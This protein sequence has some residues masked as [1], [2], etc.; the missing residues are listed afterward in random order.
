MSEATPPSKLSARDAELLALY[1]EDLLTDEQAIELNQR[2]H[3]EPTLLSAIAQYAEIEEHLRALLEEEHAADQGD[4]FV[5]MSELRDAEQRAEAVLAEQPMKTKPKK[6]SRRNGEDTPSAKEVAD[7]LWY[8]GKR[9]VVWGPV[10]AVL[11]VALTLVVA[12]RGGESQPERIVEQP[13]ATSEPVPVGP[14]APATPPIVAAL[15]AEYNAQWQ[16]APGGIAP[17][18]GD[19]LAQGLRLVLAGGAVQLTTRS[20]AVVTLQGPT[21]ARVHAEGRVE[22]VHGRLLA[23]CETPE[24]KGFTVFTD[25]AE[26]TDIGT[27]FAVERN[28]QG[29]TITGVLDGHVALGYKV[30]QD[31]P[32]ILRTGDVAGVSAQGVALAPP[33][34]Q[35][36]QIFEDWAN[37]LRP[38]AVSGDA[39]FLERPPPSFPENDEKVHVYREPAGVVLRED[40]TVSRTKPGIYRPTEQR[41]QAV[42]AAGTRVDSYFVHINRPSRPTHRVTRSFTVSFDQPVIALIAHTDLI[43]ESNGRLGDPASRYLKAGGLGLVSKSGFAPDA[44]QVDTIEWSDDRKTLTV[45]LNVEDADQ[46]RVLTQ[47]AAVPHPTPTP[48]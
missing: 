22:L 42:V 1:A 41:G 10:A 28:A 24:S 43:I 19:E 26:V 3:G 31:E 35:A 17:R 18:V 27:V 14:E 37:L 44:P 20:G 34:T 47:S 45:T 5:L 33:P 8:L 11:V 21:E 15:T 38:V 32:R 9:P 39:V 6:T 13:D 16:T 48:Q 7:V 30:S 2:L 36:A 4:W 12:F 29:Q 40:L 46:F 23:R 25:T